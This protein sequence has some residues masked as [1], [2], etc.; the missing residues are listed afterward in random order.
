MSIVIRKRVSDLFIVSALHPQND[1]VD[2]LF[3]CT[4]VEIVFKKLIS[5]LYTEEK[6]FTCFVLITV[7]SEMFSAVV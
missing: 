5:V 4:N 7:K 1:F 2:W 6:C 3:S